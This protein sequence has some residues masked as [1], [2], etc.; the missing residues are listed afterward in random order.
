[1]PN[2]VV[3]FEVIGRDPVQTQQF[4]GQ[5]FGWS[6][7][8]NNPWNYG[9]VDN[10]GAG[11]NGGISGGEHPYAT[12]YVQVEDPQATLDKVTAM[13]GTVVMPVTEIPGEVTIAI[14]ADKDGN[15]VGL[16]KGR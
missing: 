1:M 13:G 12:F 10:G 4:Y 16:M 3:H 2:P 9:I 8:A 14:F 11:I 7:D 6:I 5:L 15:R